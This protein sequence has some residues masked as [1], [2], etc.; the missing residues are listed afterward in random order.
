MIEIILYISS[1]NFEID[2]SFVILESFFIKIVRF[3]NGFT[4]EI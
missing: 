2:M 1:R 3:R 4:C